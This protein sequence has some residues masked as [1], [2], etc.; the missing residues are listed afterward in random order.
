MVN[1]NRQILKPEDVLNTAQLIGFKPS[2]GANIR[3]TYV[4]QLGGEWRY[5]LCRCVL[6]GAPQT[7]IRE[8]YPEYTFISTMVPDFS[9]EAFITAL[10][11]TG[12]SVSADM[13]PILIRASHPNWKEELVPSHA[14]GALPW[15]RFVVTATTDSFFVEKQLVAFRKPFQPSAERYLKQLLGPAPFP[16]SVDGR[17]GELWIEMED[18]RGRIHLQDNRLSITG[19]AEDLCLVGQFGDGK[20]ILLGQ[21]DSVAV[22][23]QHLG[24]VELWLLTSHDEILDYWSS[25]QWLYKYRTA[26]ADPAHDEMLK[27]LIRRG[28]YESCEFKP[29]I[30]LNK[31]GNAKASELER[32]VCAFSNLNGG[33]LLIGVDKYAEVENIAGHL[34]K[35]YGCGREDA[36]NRY[37]RDLR[38][39]LQ[40]HLKDNQ[41]FTIEPAE[42]Y[43]KLIIVV[44]VVKSRALNY[45]LESNLA[46]IR[47][48]ATSA[49]MSPEEIQSF[50]MSAADWASRGRAL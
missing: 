20:P 33:T 35:D 12:Y 21:N 8:Q 37:V 24:N 42:V 22:D 46:F 36:V 11:G 23:D 7:E 47:H 44:A 6:G 28:E 34:V 13:P 9:L 32:T 26:N 48:G 27:S 15:K 4:R 14:T 49:K 3:V 16:G 38:L 19:V 1:Q 17:K 30:D 2:D 40:E 25:T 29:Y 5:L 45:L 39:R 41:C 43:E 50:T 10:E 18:P 31:K